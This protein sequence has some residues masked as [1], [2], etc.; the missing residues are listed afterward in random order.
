MKVYLVGGAVRDGFLGKYAKDKDWV[1]VGATPADMIANGFKQVGKDFP[2]FLHPETKEE[3]ALARTER[4][5]GKGYTGFVTAFSPDVTL[6]E[7]LARRDLTINAIARDE[8]GNIIDPYNGLADIENKVLRHVTPAFVEDPLRILR[9]ARFKSRFHKLGFEVAEDTNLL[10]KNIVARGELQHLTAERVWAE[11]Q[12]ALLEP[13]PEQYFFALL[14]CNALEWVF[15]EVF[16]LFGVPQRKI[17]HPEI[18]TGLHTMMALSY[19]AKKNFCAEIRFAVLVHDLGKADTDPGLLPRHIGHE[20]RSLKRVKEMCARLKIPKSYEQLAMIVAEFHTLCHQ[21]LSLK[22]ATVLKLLEKVDAFR[23][24]ERFDLFVQA[25]EADARGRKGFE[26]VEYP[27]SN[28]L[29]EAYR[30]SSA[31]GVEKIIA[32]G[33]KGVEIGNQLKQQRLRAIKELKQSYERL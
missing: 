14:D 11:T 10:M 32:E 24:P 5:S 13:S 31:L 20:I 3:Y 18:D 4:K 22:P 30:I 21:A 16:R 29:L 19:A 17:Y 27:Q 33:Y 12:S 15:P 1:V 2:V 23:R 6:E 9:V 28:Y 8:A 25:C 7:D 26:N